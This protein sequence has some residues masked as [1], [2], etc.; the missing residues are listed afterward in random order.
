MYLQNSTLRPFCVTFFKLIGS[1]KMGMLFN[2]VG[3][4]AAHSIF[5]A[6]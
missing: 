2:A 5:T 3:I 1:H 6:L 4:L